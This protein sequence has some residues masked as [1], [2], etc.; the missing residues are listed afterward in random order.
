MTVRR[1]AASVRPPSRS[2]G[3]VST[4]LVPGATVLVLG[5]TPLVPVGAALDRL[6]AALRPVEAETRSVA[7]AVGLVLSEPIVAGHGIPPHPVALRRGW[8]VAAADTVGASSYA[9]IPYP[10]PPALVEAG[11]RLGP[12]ADAVLPLAAVSLDGGHP[13]ITDGVAPGEGAR[14]AGEDAAAGTVLRA[15]GRKVRPLDV[16]VASSAGAGTCSVRRARLR[17]AS[18]GEPDEAAAILVAG[19]AGEAG[20]AVE[21]GASTLAALTLPGADLVVLLGPCAHT[22]QAWEALGGAG[23]VVAS[24][25]ALRP[26]EGIGCGLVEGIPVLLVP[27]RVEEAL[28]ATMI[29]IRPCLDRLMGA[30]G[31]APVTGRLTRKLS[32]TV[33]LTEIALLRDDG[34][35]GLEPL[36]IAD[37]T[38]TALARADAWLAVPAEREG[39]PAGEVVHAVRL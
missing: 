2:P 13:E 34:A 26:G 37:L 28:A 35:G 10:G 6:L 9:P 38:L 15:A 36:G 31:P 30:A 18:A 17:M 20:A 24:G 1:G 7:E 21:R 4:A 3:P 8:A 39:Y 5:G 25:L 29:L 22:T 11:D 19:A 14:R 12:G 16:A 27:G 33:G 32:S 23:E